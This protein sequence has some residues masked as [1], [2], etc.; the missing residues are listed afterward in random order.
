[1]RKTTVTSKG[2]NAIRMTPI[3]TRGPRTAGDGY[4]M[5]KYD[6]PRVRIEDMDPVAIVSDSNPR[7]RSRNC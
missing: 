7:S 3:S 6:G 2:R 5:I 1:M 4:G